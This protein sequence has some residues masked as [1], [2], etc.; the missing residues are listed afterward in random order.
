[1][2]RFRSKLTRCLLAY[3][4]PRD[5]DLNQLKLNCYSISCF[6]FLDFSLLF[7]RASILFNCHVFNQNAVTYRL[8]LN[9]PHIFSNL[10]CL[11]DFI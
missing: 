7:S 1:M 8:Y 2:R 3:G 4:T 6:F 11:S 5:A 9:F 10:K